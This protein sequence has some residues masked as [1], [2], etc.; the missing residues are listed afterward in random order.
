MKH[1][2]LK[3]QLQRWCIYFILLFVNAC[4][5]STTSN[6]SLPRDYQTIEDEHSEEVAFQDRQ[7][8][9]GTM[10]FWLVSNETYMQQEQ[11]Q[12]YKQA[13]QDVLEKFRLVYPNIKVLLEVV[14]NDKVVG[15]YQTAVNSG[16]G[17]DLIFLE[18]LFVGKLFNQNLLSPIPP[19]SINRSVYQEHALPQV[20]YEDNLYAIPATSGTQVLCYNKSK[21]DATPENIYEL[22]ELSRQGY[23]VGILS[24]FRDTLWG[25]NIFGGRLFASNGK[26]ILD[27]GG[28]SNWLKFLKSLR[29]EPNIFLNSDPIALQDAFTQG[30]LTFMTCWSFDIPLLREKIGKDN[31]GV[32]LLPGLKNRPAAPALTGA[33]FVLNPVSSA[34]QQNLAITLAK[35]FTNRDQQVQWVL[36]WQASIPVNRRAIIDP[37]LFPIQGTLQKQSLNAIDYPLEDIEQA[38]IVLLTVE[39]LYRRVMSGT[40]TPD[41][42]AENI[43][44]LIN[45]QQHQN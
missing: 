20:T 19:D 24:T 8:L 37:R 44:K 6:I 31:L 22:V 5:S 28:W 7:Y 12:Q 36:R 16:L 1:S 45:Q 26:A 21:I 3:S 15:K 17:P 10:L 13:F 42:A 14:P 9:S 27:Q 32:T 43:T 38:Q 18:N 4:A 34:H 29:D 33:S 11:I 40:M 30:R 35:F 39:Q 41:M 23:S 2:S 25:A